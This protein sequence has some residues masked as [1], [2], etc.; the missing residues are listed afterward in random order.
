MFRAE[1]EEPRVPAQ[2]RKQARAQ[3]ASLLLLL[4]LL[5]RR[6]ACSIACAAAV[7]STTLHVGTLGARGAGSADGRDGGPL[8]GKAAQEIIRGLLRG[9]R[10][11]ARLSA[12][13]GTLR[14]ARLGSSI[15]SSLGALLQASARLLDDVGQR[16]VRRRRT[17]LPNTAAVSARPC[18]SR[19]V[20][21]ARLVSADEDLDD[22]R[23]REPVARENFERSAHL[24]GAPEIHARYARDAGRH[25]RRP[26]LCTARS[27]KAGP[28]AA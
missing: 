4:L 20:R 8:R 12:R 25:V 18:A 28:R 3:L 17:H 26:A 19:R 5:R 9:F 23:P 10:R 15:G 14:Y 11:R 24:R 2:V 1:H 16:V 21:R 6:R 22:F 13:L 27:S 7:D